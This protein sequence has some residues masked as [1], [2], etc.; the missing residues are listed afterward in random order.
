MR[1]I[2]LYSAPAQWHRGENVDLWLLVCMQYL[3]STSNTAG[4][5][6]MLLFLFFF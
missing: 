6:H 1:L 2:H 3:K 4:H 5:A